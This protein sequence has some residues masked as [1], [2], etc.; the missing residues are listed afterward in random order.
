MKDSICSNSDALSLNNTGIKLSVIDGR[1]VRFEPFKFLPMM[2]CLAARF[3]KVMFVE[4]H[5]HIVAI[6]SRSKLC[7]DQGQTRF[8]YYGPSLFE[9]G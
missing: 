8:G 2:V 4:D 6:I 9:D 5:S 1:Y 3:R 7:I